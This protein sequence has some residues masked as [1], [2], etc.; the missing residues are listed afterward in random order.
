MI[1]RMAKIFPIVVGKLT[2]IVLFTDFGLEGPYAC[3]MKA[4][5]TPIGARHS[6]LH[7]EGDPGIRFPALLFYATRSTTTTKGDQHADGNC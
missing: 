1:L 4:A 5:G 6:P 3:H 2:M 7:R